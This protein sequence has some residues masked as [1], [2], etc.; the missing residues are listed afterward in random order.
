MSTI[1]IN[2]T[3]F[4]VPNGASVSIRN[5]DITVGGVECNGDVQCG[6]VAGSVGA[7]A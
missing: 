7:A 1:T 5:G 2:G 6:D 4:N 3:V